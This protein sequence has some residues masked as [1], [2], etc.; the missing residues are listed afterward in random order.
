MSRFASSVRLLAGI[1]PG[2]DVLTKADAEITIGHG[3]MF[4]Q[5]CTI[6]FYGK[7][8]IGDDCYF[9]R[10]CYLV[11]HEQLTIGKKRPSSSNEVLQP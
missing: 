5:D 4:M 6:H 1:G 2:H 3:V 7:V 11:A 8:E 10:G 9:N